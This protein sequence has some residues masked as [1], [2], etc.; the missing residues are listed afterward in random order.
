MFQ[1]KVILKNGWCLQISAIKLFCSFVDVMENGNVNICLYVS[2]NVYFFI[3]LRILDIFCSKQ[4]AYFVYLLIYTKLLYFQISRNL[5]TIIFRNLQK[6]PVPQAVS[7]ADI[8]KKKDVAAPGHLVG[9]QVG[10]LNLPPPPLAVSQSQ[11]VPQNPQH[12]GGQIPIHAHQQV[13]QQM[14]QQVSGLCCA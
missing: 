9:P 14:L 12:I 6:A 8:T 5:N 1:K 7:A 2:E 11:N 4:F 3:F 10:G 13:Y